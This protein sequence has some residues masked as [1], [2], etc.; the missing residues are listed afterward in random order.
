[1]LVS[2]PQR[3]EHGGADSREWS[4]GPEEIGECGRA[5]SLR[6]P[7]VVDTVCYR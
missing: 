3:G 6:G 4:C 1:M 7:E 2:T 5:G